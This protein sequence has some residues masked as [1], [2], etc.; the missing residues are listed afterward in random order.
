MVFRI[1][2][3]NLVADYGQNKLIIGCLCQQK[4]KRLCQ[5]LNL[6]DFEIAALTRVLMT[7]QRFNS[8]ELPVTS[9]YFELVAKLAK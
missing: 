9:G 6:F 7:P 1:T 3:N 4:E 8:S 2:F 5:K